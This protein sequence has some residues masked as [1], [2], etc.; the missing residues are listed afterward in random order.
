M[1]PQQLASLLFDAIQI[2]RYLAE[3]SAFGGSDIEPSVRSCFSKAA[4]GKSEAE[5]I[6]TLS[7]KQFIQWLQREPQSMVWLPVLHR[8]SAAEMATH[9][10]KCRACKVFPIVGFRYHCLKCFNFDLCHNCFFVGRT[11]K[12]H[13]ADH[14]TQEYC[15]STGRSANFKIL[16]Q[17]IR[18]SF[19]TKKYFKKKGSKL[20]YL[21]VGSLCDGN[22]FSPTISP[23]MSINSRQSEADSVKMTAVD[24]NRHTTSV[25]ED[26]KPLD[27]H[28]LI[29]EYCRMIQDRCNDTSDSNNVETNIKELES[30]RKALLAEYR[31]LT[32]KVPTSELAQLELSPPTLHLDEE[33]KNLKAQTARMEARMKILL[34]H[35]HQLESQLKRLRQLVNANIKN[36]G[37]FGTLQSRSVV[38]QDLHI[39]SPN[40]NCK[41]HQNCIAHVCM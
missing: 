28:S 20:G 38:A 7:C 18:N 25:S 41:L 2:P 17:A 23:N 11:A 3:V 12:G 34:D 26:D 31:D 29:A 27:E 16:G 24:N 32:Q 30:E 8:L 22:E 9:N 10:T 14:P 15:T 13:K 35:N 36:E 33:T 5:F 19:R 40:Q 37:Q 39:Q 6:E 4:C 21:P 1:T